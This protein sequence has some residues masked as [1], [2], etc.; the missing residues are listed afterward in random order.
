[1][2]VCMDCGANIDHRG[3]RAIRCESCSGAHKKTRYYRHG[4]P[5]KDCLFDRKPQS[6]QCRTCLYFSER[7]GICDYFDIMGKT[8]SS[9]HGN[10]TWGLNNPCEEYKERGDKRVPS[11]VRSISLKR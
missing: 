10:R 2:R 8:R 9:L 11:R 5:L 7:L 3:N 4:I 1:M 6:E